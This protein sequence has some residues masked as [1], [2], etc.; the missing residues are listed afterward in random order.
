MLLIRDEMTI[1]AAD[2]PPVAVAVVVVVVVLA[3][4]GAV[5]HATA[6]E[7]TRV[8]VEATLPR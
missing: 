8:L 2:L 3:L 5:H 1:L 6:L 7:I 4:R